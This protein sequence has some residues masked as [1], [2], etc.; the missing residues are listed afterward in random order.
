MSLSETE[1]QKQLEQMITFIN[2][3][4]D[5]RVQELRAI[6]EE[7]SSIEKGKK[8]QEEKLKILQEFERKEREIETQKKIDQSQAVNSARLKILKAREQCLQQLQLEAQKSLS[9]ISKDPVAYKKLLQDLIVQGLM[10]LKENK[11]A[12]VGRVQDKDIIVS[13]MPL[14]ASKYEE[15][16]GKQVELI[17]DHENFLPPGPDRAATSETG[18]CSGGVILSCDGGRIICNNTLD[19]RLFLAFEQRLPEVRTKLYGPSYA[20]QK[21]KNPPASAT[22]H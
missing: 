19:A 7:E 11:V 12:V 18:L 4:A 1:V 5:D 15:K 2:S 10:K 20:I 13:I 3:E 8:V 21:K 6:A 17:F 9:T 16:S 14:A 22:K